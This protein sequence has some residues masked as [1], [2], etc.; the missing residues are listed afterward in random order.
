MTPT[1]RRLR[2]FRDPLAFF[3]ACALGGPSLTAHAAD[4][5]V[6]STVDLPDF[7]AQDNVCDGNPSAIVQCTVRAA[8]MHSQNGDV[9]HLQQG[10]TYRLSIPRDAADSNPENGNLNI[11]D[12]TIEIR[13]DGTE[14]ARILVKEILPTAEPHERFSAI[15]VLATNGQ[16]AS[17]TL[18]NV[19]V[20]GNNESIPAGGFDAEGGGGITC[21]GVTGGNAMLI[22]RNRSIVRNFVV[23]SGAG[24]IL[25]ATGCEASIEGSIIEQNIGED[26]AGIYV[27]YNASLEMRASTLRANKAD[28]AG[29]AIARGL[30]ANVT[31]RN[32]TITGNGA[33]RGSA[34]F[35]ESGG[36]DVLQNVTITRNDQ[37]NRHGHEALYAFEVVQAPNVKISNSIIADNRTARVDIANSPDIVS[38]GHNLFGERAPEIGNIVTT[39]GDSI[40][41]GNPEL[42]SNLVTLPGSLTRVPTLPPI[43]A[44]G[45]ISPAVNA[46]NPAQPNG[47]DDST[48]FITDANGAMRATGSCDIGAAEC[49]PSYVPAPRIRMLVKHELVTEGQ[50]FEVEF[51]L[52]NG[53]LA[54]GQQATLQFAVIGEQAEE[55]DD[56]ALPID[57]HVTFAGGGPTTYT[58]QIPTLDDTLDEFLEN[59]EIAI[60]DLP[61]IALDGPESIGLGIVDNDGMPQI[62]IETVVAETWETMT[63]PDQG[64]LR[65]RIELSE[66]SSHA[67]TVPLVIG[68]DATPAVDHTHSDF[69]DNFYIPV[70]ETT[71]FLDIFAY[72]DLEDGEPDETVTVRIDSL[73]LNYAE[74]GANDRATAV[75]H[76]G[77]QPAADGTIFSDGF[78]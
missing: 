38:L 26:G 31:L 59:L 18:D 68:G 45:V 14:A 44:G 52:V 21:R 75:I 2:P 76:D 27:G 11:I 29:G 53:M 40:D 57:N 22:L 51:S 42:A 10:T 37:E 1:T 50:N 35:A 34:Y 54:V 62:Q 67:I 61:G 33:N 28:D 72:F 56:Y 77:A 47:A 69:V 3:V 49:S 25:V 13:T 39:V 70:G 8:V 7:S 65:F 20:S 15:G 43:C 36:Q 41:I 4:I 32:V 16:D 48:C 19:V 30:S 66:P 78:E 71:M 73:G 24:G 63:G 9:I 6:N 64:L 12:K 58:V 55:G 17:L 74:V 46:G 60:T 23:E 5:F